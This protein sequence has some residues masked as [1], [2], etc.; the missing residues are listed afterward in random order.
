MKT[1]K[2]LIVLLFF[3]FYS[4]KTYT[5]TPDSFKE[6]ILKV[7][8]L[9]MKPDA[10]SKVKVGLSKITFTYKSNGINYIKVI[11]KK[12][13]KDLIQNSP[14]IEM[15]ITLK[16]NKKHHFYFDTVYLQ[17]DTLFGGKSRFIP[18]IITK[19]P[20]EEIQK[21]EIQDGGKKFNEK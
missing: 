2:L 12:G 17:N 19:I 3:L 7:N 1:S 15:R 20:F 9:S 6:Q 10:D 4:C 11:D 13:E 16:N 8:P 21:I 5:I 14:S 18:N